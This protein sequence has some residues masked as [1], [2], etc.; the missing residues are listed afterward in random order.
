MKSLDRFNII[1]AARASKSYDKAITCIDHNRFIAD[2][3]AA[4]KEQGLRVEEG[5]LC[6]S[7]GVKY[8]VIK[9]N[10]VLMQITAGIGKWNVADTVIL[11][12]VID[13]RFF[14]A[15]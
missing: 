12:E 5:V 11:G 7:G 3:E 15:E 1:S 4:L 14:E 6:G 13:G 2:R 8:V 9:K 10:Q